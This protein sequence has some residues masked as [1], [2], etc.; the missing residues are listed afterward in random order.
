[1]SKTTA[2]TNQA[3]NMGNTKV[4]MIFAVVFLVVCICTVLFFKHYNKGLMINKVATTASSGEMKEV[5]IFDD[6][7]ILVNSDSVLRD[8]TLFADVDPNVTAYL[9]KSIKNGDTII[10]VNYGIGAYSLFMAKLAG[11]AGRIYVYNPSIRNASSLMVSAKLNKFSD[12]VFVK[13]FGISN[14]TFD[15]ALVY[16]TGE[17]PATGHIEKRDFVAPKGYSRMQIQVSSIDEQL[18]RLQNIDV[19]KINTNGDESEAINGAIN[20]IKK[21][22]N[23]KIIV[24][25]SK[26]SFNGYS[27]LERLILLGFNLF[28]ISDRGKEKPISIFELKSLEKGSILLKRGL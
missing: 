25:F 16:K 4:L 20:L 10:D 22:E 2:K 3:H 9:R 12:R 21:S 19:L 14:H 26:D 27:V 17:S 15:G 28:I 24:T 11:Q 13:E 1:M 5:T 18:P 23:I 8:S 7:K 6:I